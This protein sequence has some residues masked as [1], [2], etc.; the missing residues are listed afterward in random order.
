MSRCGQKT[1]K[2]DRA[3]IYGWVLPRHWLD[4]EADPITTKLPRTV[5]AEEQ[6]E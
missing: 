6:D 4:C 2:M 3:I 5:S 1:V